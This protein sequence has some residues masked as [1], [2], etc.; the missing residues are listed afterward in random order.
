MVKNIENSIKIAFVGDVFLGDQP[1]KIGTDLFELLSQCDHVIANL[2]TPLCMPSPIDFSKILLRSEPGT[3]NVL[4]EWGITA[5]TL[6]NNH[7]FDHGENGFKAT[8]AALNT[9]Q[10]P[11]AGAGMNRSEAACPL[12]FEI[13]AFRIA[14][15]ACTEPGTQAQIA[16]SNTP[17]CH[18][19][20]FPDIAAQIQS[21]KQEGH[22]VIVVPHWGYCD[23]EYPS[24]EVVENG[25][26]L[27]AAGADLVI[28]HHS[29]VVQ[30]MNQRSSGQVIAY[31]LGN[32]YFGDYN[33][34]GRKVSTNGESNRG[35][36]LIVEFSANTLPEVQKIY[37]CQKANQIDLDANIDKRENEFQQRCVP[38]Y[39]LSNYP[40]YW[41]KVV[42]KRLYRRLTH[43]L[44]PFNW[45]EMKWATINA[46]WIMI[47]QQLLR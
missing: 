18:H 8:R 41:P 4:R 25:E 5:V 20:T 15:I 46:L 47:K 45:H 6:A 17:G 43:W 7:I 21:I 37:T 33:F 11:F 13:G 14:I 28:G 12:T 26:K 30:G 3:E 44:N 32:F 23:Y 19:L 27:L 39:D 31:S 36:C 1:G 22:I 2:E 40:T 10:I 38:L 29:H 16:T 35:L 24:Q 34:R 42:R 9:L